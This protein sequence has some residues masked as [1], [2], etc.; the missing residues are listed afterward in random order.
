MND[1]LPKCPKIYKNKIRLFV[2]PFVHRCK[3]NVQILRK[4]SK[5]DE[6]DLDIADLDIADLDMGLCFRDLLDIAVVGHCSFGHEKLDIFVMTRS[7][8]LV[9]L[10]E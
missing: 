4:I 3:K 2:R 1:K 8:T 7:Q 9:F 5:C 6:F 10:K